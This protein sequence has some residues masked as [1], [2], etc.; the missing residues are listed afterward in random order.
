MRSIRGRTSQ[1][2]ILLKPLPFEHPI[3]ANSVREEITPAMSRRTSTVE[4]ALFQSSF[5]GTE[6]TCFTGASQVEN[7]MNTNPLL[8]RGGQFAIR[9]PLIGSLV[10]S[11]VDGLPDDAICAEQ[12]VQLVICST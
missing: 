4:A 11:M 10:P 9:C 3:K 12:G 5:R 7:R 1:W 8:L 2:G 6:T